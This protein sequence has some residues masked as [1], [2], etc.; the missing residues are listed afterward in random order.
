MSGECVCVCVF[1]PLCT[2]NSVT[3]VCCVSVCLPAHL[4]VCG[5]VHA[6]VRQC[7]N[8]V[9]SCFN[10]Y[11]PPPRPPHLPL[12]HSQTKTHSLVYQ[13]TPKLF[14][15][16]FCPVHQAAVQGYNPPNPPPSHSL[17]MF[18]GFCRDPQG[19]APVFVGCHCLTL[20]MSYV[21]VCGG[22]GGVGAR[23]EQMGLPCPITPKHPPLSR[24]REKQQE[25]KGGGGGGGK[26]E[27]EDC[28]ATPSPR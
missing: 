11:L 27:T 23:D 4:T 9:H 10:A 6:L 22:W 15:S 2:F 8:K 19:T 20:V 26:E 21:C 17:G 3:S 16:G 24:T 5:W 12:Q 25:E 18:P 1:Q 7:M 28:L 13:G 14:F